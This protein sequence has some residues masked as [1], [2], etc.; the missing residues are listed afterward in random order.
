MVDIMDHCTGL[1]VAVAAFVSVLI[2]ALYAAVRADRRFRK[3]RQQVAAA[4]PISN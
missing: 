4:A 1:C 3:M 2:P